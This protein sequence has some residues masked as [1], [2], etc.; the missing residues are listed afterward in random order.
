[1]GYRELLRTQKTFRRLWLGQIVSQCGDWLQL[2]AL[3]VL[4]PTSGEAVNALAGIFIVRMI[5]WIVWAPLAGVV[6]D[7]FR[8]RGG[9]IAADLARAV[10]VLGY[11]FV[12]DAS[13]VMLVYAIAFTQESL[14]AFFEPARS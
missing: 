13:D 1:M 12:R 6:A 11:L 14:S 9:M 2:I 4:F 7:R 3:L 8:R 10:V 5:P